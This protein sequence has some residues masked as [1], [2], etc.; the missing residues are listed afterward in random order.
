LTRVHNSAKV[1]VIGHDKQID[2][3]DPKKSGFVPYLEHFRN[4]PYCKV[5]ELHVNFRGQLAQHADNLNW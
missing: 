2:L 3:K 1:I 5:V 4:E